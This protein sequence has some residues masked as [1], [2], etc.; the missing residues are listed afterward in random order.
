MT[1]RIMAAAVVMVVVAAAMAAAMAGVARHPA[2]FL[3]RQNNRR[4]T[5]AMTCQVN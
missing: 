2:P 1:L 4:F 3:P 5:F